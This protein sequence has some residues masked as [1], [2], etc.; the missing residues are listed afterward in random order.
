MAIF[1]RLRKAKQAADNQKGKMAATAESKPPAAPYKH[2]P[3]HAASDALLGAP[4]TWREQ[5]KKAIQDQHLK[6]AQSNLA[7]NRSS[8]SNVTTLNHDQTFTSSDRAHA[9]TDARKQYSGDWISSS[10]SHRAS[11]L[12]SVG[13]ATT[14]NHPI[15][16]QRPITDLTPRSSNMRSNRLDVLAEMPQT[17]SPGDSI[18]VHPYS[19]VERPSKDF[20]FH[21]P[22][23]RGELVMGNMI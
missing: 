2:I 15:N 12:A 3:T 23:S 22:L 16:S 14:T 13:R 1:S 9:T 5:D 11:Q 6:R 18:P 7:R 20:K 4:A 17:A 8:L 21:L 19:G 10:I